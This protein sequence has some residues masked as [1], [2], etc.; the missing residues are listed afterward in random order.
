MNNIANLT[1]HLLNHYNLQ[2]KLFKEYVYF[3]LSGNVLKTLLL[4]TYIYDITKNI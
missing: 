2:S 1:E 4:I 3:H